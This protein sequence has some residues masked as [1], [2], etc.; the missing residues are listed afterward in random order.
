[1]GHFAL[2]TALKHLALET[3]HPWTSTLE[4]ADSGTQ[5]P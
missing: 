2:E 5:C 4:S 3:V 1:M